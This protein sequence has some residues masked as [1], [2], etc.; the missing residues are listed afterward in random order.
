[1][2]LFTAF[3]LSLSC[4]FA[5]DLTPRIGLGG[6]DTVLPHLVAGGPFWK[7]TITL[8][9]VGTSMAS[10]TLQFHHD[11]GNPWDVL[12]ANQPAATSALSGTI[13]VGGAVT[14]TTVPTLSQFEMQS[15]WAQL[16]N[17]NFAVAPI[18]MWGVFSLGNHLGGSVI[19]N[20]S[21]AVVPANS[22]QDTTFAVPFDNT[23][24]MQFGVGFTNPHTRTV[25]ADLIFRGEDG[26]FLF[27][28]TLTLPGLGHKALQ[29]ADL[30][31]GG[32][33]QVAN[34]KGV[35]FVNVLSGD[36]IAM[37]GL[38]FNPANTFTSVHT[39]YSPN[40]GEPPQ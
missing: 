31:S 19:P 4:A 36:S 27:K 34:K 10:Y 17:N 23:N 1:V 35:M 25:M 32:W 39:V 9:N 24:G 12:V 38:R 33:P 5:A 20:P 14:Y 29:T 3:L 15:G 18:A 26:S 2:K 40:N 6:H 8:V 11:D 13:P 30:K 21:E 7:T 22:D 28:T 37:L 16:I